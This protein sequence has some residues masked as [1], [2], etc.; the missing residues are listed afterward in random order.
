MFD[1][2]LDKTNY[3][4]FATKNKKDIVI[5]QDAQL[6]L[7]EIFPIPTENYPQLLKYIQNV[8]VTFSMYDNHNFYKILDKSAII[9]FNTPLNELNNNNDA[10]TDISDFTI[11]YHFTENDL[12]KAGTYIGEFKIIFSNND[13]EKTLIVPIRYPI[14]IT[15]LQSNNKLKVTSLPTLIKNDILLADSGNKFLYADENT[16]LLYT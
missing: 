16:Y 15:V 3:F 13:E 2:T 6:P 1:F 7:V 11:Q 12:S 14:R 5:T 10:C 8:S 4:E 9:N